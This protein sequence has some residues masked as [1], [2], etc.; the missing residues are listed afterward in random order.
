MIDLISDSF[1]MLESDMLEFYGKRSLG[2]S[3]S[4]VGKRLLLTVVWGE[5]VMPQKWCMMYSC[6]EVEWAE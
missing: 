1:G 4:G 3:E 2:K 6:E 5:M